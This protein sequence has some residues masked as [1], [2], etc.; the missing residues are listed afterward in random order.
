MRYE[1]C[2]AEMFYPLPC[3]LSMSILSAI[4]IPFSFSNARRRELQVALYPVE[5]NYE[6]LAI[7]N[8]AD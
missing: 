3:F 4:A 5:G 1:N 7:N 8:L 6:V 2:C